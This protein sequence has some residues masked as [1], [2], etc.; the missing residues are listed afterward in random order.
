MVNFQGLLF[1]SEGKGMVERV[2]TLAKLGIRMNLP[3]D[4]IENSNPPRFRWRQLVSTPSGYQTVEHEGGL[5]PSVEA[6]VTMLITM[7][8]QQARS[9]DDLKQSRSLSTSRPT[10]VSK[11]K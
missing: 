8:K 2:A 1:S 6:A 10:S 3:I 9:I 7:V 4:I 11:G 5:P